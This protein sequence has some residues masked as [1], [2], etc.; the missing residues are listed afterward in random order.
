VVLRLGRYLGEKA[1]R[2]P[3]RD[4]I[5]NSELPLAAPIGPVVLVVEA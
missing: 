4:G 2:V 3:G 5:G 1:T